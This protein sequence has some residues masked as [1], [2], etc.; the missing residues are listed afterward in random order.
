MTGISKL[1]LTFVLV[2]CAFAL[3]TS[4]Q[5]ANCTFT[6]F[7]PP[8]PYNVAFQANGINHY[9]TVVGQ[10][11][12]NTV[13]KGFT[14]SSGGG[15]SLFSV[16]GSSY[17][18]FNKRNHAGTTVGFYLP[19]GSSNS[20]GLVR[21][22]SGWEA[23]VYP[24]AVMTR[25]TGINKYNTIVGAYASS[26]TGLQHGFR[27][28]NGSFSKINFPGAV[29]TIPTAINDN[30]VIVGM[31]WL[32]TLENSPHGFILQSGTYKSFDVSGSAGTQP[33]DISNGGTIVVG[34]NILYKNGTTKQV[35]V[36]N[37]F[38][39]FV[40]GINDVSKITGVANYSQG[41]NT[42]TWKAFVGSCTGL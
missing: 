33:S 21:T 20:K 36:P 5:T 17:T 14:R 37:A 1:A 41:N 23:L 27:F 6:Y 9:N 29:Q 35:N 13:V 40:Y 30:G 25:A 38:E 31:Y 4:A 10:A 26:S 28:S 15:I 42:F 39:T 2:V 7:V 12:S 34:P 24:G 16:P 18:S 8:S 32:G 11:S 19:S 22:S 3:T